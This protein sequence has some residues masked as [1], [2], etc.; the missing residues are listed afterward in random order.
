[1]A[2]PTPRRRNPLLLALAATL[3]AYAASEVLFTRVLTRHLPLRAHGALHEGARVL[4]QS[5]KAGTLPH[6]YIALAG[7]SYAA[8]EGDWYLSSDG[9]RNTPFHSAHLIHEAT[10]RDVVTFGG[11]GGGSL[12]CLVAEPAAQ[13][14]FL[15]AHPLLRVEDPRILLV[16]FYEG[17]DL[18]DNDHDISLRTGNLALPAAFFK[19]GGFEDWANRNVL[20]IAPVNIAAR[21]PRPRD[22]LLF[23]DFCINVF[24]HWLGTMPEPERPAP[25]ASGINQARIAGAIVALPDQLQAPLLALDDGAVSCGAKIFEL[26]L[27]YAVR[28]FP[29]TSV[30]VLYIPSPLACYDLASTEVSVHCYLETEKARSFY[31]DDVFLRSDLLYGKIAAAAQTVGVPCHDARPALRA[32]ARRQPIHGPRDW[33]HLNRAGHHALASAAVELVH[34]VESK[35]LGANPEIP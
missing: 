30:A 35:N 23:A 27:D 6:D 8:G 22:R 2:Q 9:S 28:R 26:A 31:A 34:A 16:Y 13:L 18:I 25:A 29:Q 7:D 19:P 12:R 11:S 32:A 15:N 1:M 5:S 33:A 14:A 17:N 21:T 3:V 24:R 10:G 20:A 4:C